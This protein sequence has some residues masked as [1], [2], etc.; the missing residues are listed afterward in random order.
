MP[1]GVTF[2]WPIFRIRRSGREDCMTTTRNREEPAGEARRDA[3]RRVDQISAFTS[4]LEEL[5]RGGILTLGA[6]AK[7][8]IERYHAGLLATLAQQFDVDRTEG[9]RQMALGMRIASLLGAVTLSA[10]VVLFFYR[11]WGLLT[12]PVQVA[13]LVAMP[14]VMLAAVEIAARREP[15]R[16]IAAVL[17]L[18]AAASF[19]LNLSGV[20]TI[21]NMIPSPM[22]LAAWAAFALAVAYAYGLQLLLAGGLAAAMGY[23]LSVIAAATGLDWTVSVARPEPLLVLGPAAIAASFWRPAV[24]AEGFAQ[25]FRLVGVAA[26]LLPLLFLSTWPEVFSYQPLPLGVLH[27]VYDVAG[28]ALPLVAAWFG[29][30]RRWPEMTNTA[31]GFLVLFVYAKCFDWWWDVMPRYLFFLMLGGLAIAAMVVLTKLRLRMKEV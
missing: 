13:A 21:F 18:I 31:S 17:S 16:Y 23:A 29:I 14:L 8:Q 12:T 7:G 9:Q 5:E 26:L 6:D 20:G 27:A 3:Q 28:F 24:R 22:I 30:R 25:T 10:A 11:I 15:T 19:A 2:P 1:V 4:E